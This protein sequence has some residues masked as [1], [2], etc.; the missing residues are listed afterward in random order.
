MD[1]DSREDFAKQAITYLRRHGFQ[2]LDID[3]EYPADR[4]GSRPEDKDNFSLLLQV[5][6]CLIYRN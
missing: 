2:G 3:W 4:E 5:H 6:S 1:P